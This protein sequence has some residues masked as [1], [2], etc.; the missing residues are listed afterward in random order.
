[1]KDKKLRTCGNCSGHIP[2]E[3]EHFEIENETYC[4]ECIEVHEYTAK[5]YFLAGEYMGDSES[6]D[7]VQFVESYDDDYEED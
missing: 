4:V 2:P 5:Q 7:R 1:M 6:D 3:T